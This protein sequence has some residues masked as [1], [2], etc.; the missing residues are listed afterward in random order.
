M[1]ILRTLAIVLIAAMFT[2]PAAASDKT[3]K[4]VFIAGKRSH[5]WGSHEH[6]AGSMLLADRLNKSGLPVK[7]VVVTEGWPADESIL[8]DADAIVMYSDG[9]ERHMALPHVGKLDELAK[10]GVGIGAIHY[11]VEVPKGPEAGDKWLN[12]IGGYFEPHWSVNPHWSAGFEKLPDHP[13]ANGVRGFGIHDEWYYHMRFRDGMKGITAILTD[14]P[15][16]SS[17]A[18]KDGPHSGNPEVRA[19]VLQR[20]EPQHV[21]WLYDRTAEG[22]KGRGFG[23]TGGHFHWNWGHDQFRKVVL[24]AVAWIAGI[25]VPAGGVESATPS[26]AELEQNQDYPR[27]ENWNSAKIQEQIDA[28]NAP[29]PPEGENTKAKKQAKRPDQSDNPSKIKQPEDAV[30]RAPADAVAG[31]DV[32]PELEATLFAAEPMLLSPSNMDI[33]H[34]GRV[35][36]AEVVNYRHFR[37][38]DNP[39]REAGDRILILEDTDADGRADKQTVFYQGRDIDSAH[40]V[41][42]LGNKV[43]V[44]AGENVFVLT[45][46]NG[47]DK[48]DRKDVLFTGIGGTQHDHGIHSFHFGPDGKLYFNFGNE[49]KQ[50]KDR[51][52]KPI[53]D[54]AGNEVNNSRNPY[55]EGMIFR[56]NLDG[57]EF[58]T[59][60]WNFRNN[61]E[62]AVD[63][64]GTIWQSDNDDDGNRGVRINFVME[65]GNYGYKDQ[66]TGAG[67]REPRTNLEAEIPLQHWHLND[68]GVVPNLLQ[69]GAGSPT[70]ILVYEGRLLPE[71]FHDQMIHTDAGPHIVR[72]Y[73]VEK[74][75]AGY[76]ASIVNIAE[77]VRDKW[78][79]PSD[80]TVAPDGSI[81]V[82]DWYDPGVGGHAQGDIDRGRVF[83]IAPPGSEYSVPRFD[84]E[85]IEGAIEA[86]QSPNHATR[87]LAWT[88]LHEM[89]DKAEPALKKMFE[90]EQN[91]RFRARALW[92]LSK[93]DGGSG[94]KH[95]DA[96]LKHDDADI[97]I[98]AL[99]AARQLDLDMLPLV[100]RLVN[101]PSPQVRRECAIALRHI[102][103]PQAA[104]LWASLAMQYDGTDRWY[105]EALGIGSDV[106][107][108]ACYEAYMRTAPAFSDA[109]RDVLWRLRSP[110]VLPLLAGFITDSN[111]PEAE[112]L[113]YFRAFDFHDE[114]ARQ[115][116]LMALLDANGS[117]AAQISALALK[118]LGNIDLARHPQARKAV[119]RAVAASKGTPQFISLVT[120][121]QMR[122]QIDELMRLALT[123]PNQTL[124]VDA[125]KAIVK[126]GEIDRFKT[127]IEGDDPARAAAALTVLGYTGERDLMRLLMQFARDDKMEMPVRQAAIAAFGRSREGEKWLLGSVRNGNFPPE[128]SIAAANVLHASQDAQLREEAAKHIQM[129]AAANSKPLP[130]IAELAKR[131][132]DAAAGQ[133]VFMRTCLTCHKVGETGIEFGPNLGEIGS[134]LAREDLY[135]AII[136]PNAAISFGFEGVLITTRDG[137]QRLGYITSETPSEL[138]LRMMGG[139]DA[140]IPVAD[141]AKRDKQP[142]SLMLPNLQQTMTEQ[143]LVDLVEYLASLKTK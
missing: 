10:K 131:K 70:G 89:G 41:C 78:F 116:V 142:A 132:G 138:T 31:L 37:N 71:V 88:A 72:S 25:E 120:Q 56:C 15:P 36:V 143:E 68:P 45:D 46:E 66:V 100:K 141:V 85:T 105:L 29:P 3:K 113:R 2:L 84:F 98:T 99:R 117:H 60:A 83:R 17:L 33:D 49:G 23:F 9:G 30:T 87:Y 91:P 93:L 74:Y 7:A 102:T 50:I 52:G 59:L 19:A 35:W 122:D 90:T 63:S 82:A 54:M 39:P 124:G 80:V 86:L 58:E 32:H 126:L 119:E 109:V 139:I 47:D 81:F 92:L 107:A 96:A 57:S 115:P 69:T 64:F 128:L 94:T 118:H 110:K 136:D 55:Q 67:W 44:S 108:D 4:I 127:I 12:Y 62:L 123:N 61:W 26:A 22:G 53:I 130:P 114:A 6:K 27:P 13:V 76:T 129:P 112:R 135:R 97:R 51:H 73:P 111:T 125:A 77:G 65:F 95:L 48:A 121:F 40:G 5:G 43:I 20:K 21:M 24:N 42:V 106:N 34:L 38:K 134:K 18:R 75:G 16:D 140:K 104:E 79:R 11:A 8:D 101:D 103:T 14:L 133:A 137:N 1:L 28:W